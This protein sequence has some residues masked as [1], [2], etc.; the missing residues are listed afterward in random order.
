MK[1]HDVLLALCAGCNFLAIAGVAGAI[2]M[3]VLTGETF[4]YAGILMLLGAL[5][6]ILSGT[7]LDW[8]KEA[9]KLGKSRKQKSKRP[10]RKR[11]HTD[12]A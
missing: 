4:L 8:D 10:T 11:K 5:C 2:D 12:A 1:L 9:G 3:D 7:V 6:G